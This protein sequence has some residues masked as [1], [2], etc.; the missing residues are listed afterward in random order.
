MVDL[1]K[2]LCSTFYLHICMMLL[3]ILDVYTLW[4]STSEFIFCDF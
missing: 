3:P 1:D 2:L 4:I